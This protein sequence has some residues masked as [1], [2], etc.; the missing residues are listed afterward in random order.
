MMTNSYRSFKTVV[1]RKQT[2]LSDFHKMTVT[3]IKT[4]FEKQ[5]PIIVIINF[6][7]SE[8][9]Q[10]ILYELYLLGNVLGEVSFELSY[11]YARRRFKN[12][13]L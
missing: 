8:Y 3:V 6:S 4:H 1:L 13:L 12:R 7:V 10:Q 9:R 2:G 5:K 11:I